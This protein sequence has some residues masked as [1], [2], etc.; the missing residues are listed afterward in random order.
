MIGSIRKHSAWLWWLIAIATIVAFVGWNINPGTRNG[1]GRSG[2]LG[3]LYGKPVT[4]DQVEAAKREFEIDF[5]LRNHEFPNQSVSRAEMDQAIYQR[6]MIKA[7]AQE[8]GIHVGPEAQATAANNILASIGRSVSRDGKPVQMSQFVERVLQPAGL[9]TV[10]FQRFVTDYLAQQELMEAVA[11]NGSLVSPQEA[12]QLYDHD[13]QEFS[14]QAVFFTASNFES[15]VT[16]SPAAVATFY[17]NNIANL[18]RLPNR[19][20]LNYIEYNLTNY[21]APAEQKIGKTNITTQVDTIFAQRGL[22]AVPG[23]KTPEEAKAK[24]RDAIV[25]NE[26]MKEASDD[27]KQFLTKLFAIDNVTG[28]SLV[29]LAKSEGLAVRATAP[30]S[31]KDGPEEFLQEPELAQQISAKAFE[32]NNESPFFTSPVPTSDAV[33]VIGLAN[34]LPSAIE[35]L[36]LIHDRVVQDYQREQAIILARTAGSKFYGTAVTQMA[37]GKTFAQ[38]AMASGQAPIALKPFSLSSGDIPEADNFADP[39]QIKQAAAETQVG[40]V[41][42]FQATADGGFVLFVQSML[43]VDEAAKK[44]DLPAYLS[45][46]R[47]SRQNEAFNLWMYAEENRELPNTPVMQ[48]L[49]DARPTTRGQ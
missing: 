32:L 48:E 29:T 35:P 33:Y 13:H 40:H 46:V 37:T 26:A 12:S 47:R 3:M 18:Y 30:F 9:T 49:K 11:M 4:E 20:Q 21:F 23:A 14:A 1:S 43:P 44:S 22:E 28:A 6:L 42:A 25:R 5:W 24:I 27:A 7:K 19:V 15:Q 36:N 31:E 38:A 39:R 34:D 17:S 16:V 2:G 41:S 45:Q 8:L 10:D